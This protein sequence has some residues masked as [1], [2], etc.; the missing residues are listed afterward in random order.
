VRVSVAGVAVRSGAVAALSRLDIDVAAGERR[1]VIGPNGAGNTTLLN[2]IAGEQRPTEGLV[3]LGEQDA[4]PLPASPRARLGFGRSFQRSAL[5]DQLSVAE[6][7][8]LAVRARLHGGWRFWPARERAV[9][10]E[11]QGRLEAGGIAHLARRRAA[12]LGH[13]GRRILE[14]ELA[15]AAAPPARVRNEPEARRAGA[16][17]RLTLG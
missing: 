8:T 5:F 1:A 15:L 10:T 6:N 13:G 4:T 3:H 16:E 11:V 2:V 7:V 17:R 9:N 14:I 12:R